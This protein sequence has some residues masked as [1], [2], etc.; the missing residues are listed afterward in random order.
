MSVSAERLLGGG[1]DPEANALFYGLR[2]VGGLNLWWVCR[3]KG[4]DWGV[5]LELESC[6]GV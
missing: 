1:N 2:E 4:G 3:P 5:V 6:L